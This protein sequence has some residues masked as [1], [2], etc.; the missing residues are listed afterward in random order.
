MA[1]SFRRKIERI[2][3]WQ[4]GDAVSIGRSEISNPGR[5]DHSNLREKNLFIAHSAPEFAVSRLV[6]EAA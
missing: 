3:T 4:E 2:S 6:E 1:S 5:P